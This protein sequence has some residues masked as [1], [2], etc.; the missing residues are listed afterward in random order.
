[1]REEAVLCLR[2]AAGA[3]AQGNPN[4][5]DPEQVWDQLWSILEDGGVLRTSRL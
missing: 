4:L 1:V 2:A 3:W 5:P